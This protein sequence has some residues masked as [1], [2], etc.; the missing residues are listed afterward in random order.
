MGIEAPALDFGA[1]APVIVIVT[2]AAIALLLDLFVPPS[3][4]IALGYLALA[5][6]LGALAAYLPLWNNARLAYN[7]MVAIDRF[8]VFVSVL[9]LIA[10]ALSILLALDFLGQHRLNYGEYYPLVLISAAGMLLLAIAN[11][12]IVLFLGLE[13][14]SIGLYILAG[15]ARG[16]RDSE[17]SALKYF[18]LGSFSFGFLVYGA[19][20]IYGATGTTNYAALA[21]A[22]QTGTPLNNPLLLAGFAL[23][24]VGMAFKLALAP[25]HMWTPDVYTGAPTTVTAFMSVGTKI[26]T[27]GALARLLTGALPALRADWSIALWT[28]AIITMVVGNLAAITQRNV[29]RLLAYSSIGQAG[30]ILVAVV[31]SASQRQ[32]VSDAAL[33]GILYYLLAYT[34]MNLGAF[35]VIVALARPD[36][37]RLDL[38]TDY[39]GLARQRP[40]L[41]AAMT[42]FMLSL[43][44]IPPTAGFMAKLLIFSAAVDAGFWPLALIGVLTSVIALAFYLRVI[45]MMYTREPHNTEE[46]PSR[47]PLSLAVV[48]VVC[49]ALTLQLGMLPGWPLDYAQQALTAAVR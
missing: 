43:G 19:S 22:L 17:E 44:G 6:T 28:L 18:L 23:V 41:A 35:A 48:L 32:N 8:G 45:V 30:Y 5:T 26:A 24:L 39:A 1:L 14:L 38:N 7:D 10:T 27:F 2:G 3:Q 12:L 4:R 20:L 9:V 49:V 15:F 33:S 13:V 21:Q 36:T 47:V 31:A 37:E 11:D 25:F 34:F 42:I 40:W 46:A 29:K 16:Q